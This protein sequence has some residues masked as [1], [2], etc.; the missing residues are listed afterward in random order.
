MIKIYK[1]VMRQYEEGRTTSIS[2]QEM[3][4]VSRKH[5]P[6]YFVSEFDELKQKAYHLAFHIV[7][8]ILEREEIRS[9]IPVLQEPVAENF[10]ELTCLFSLFGVT[11]LKGK[12]HQKYHPNC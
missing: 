11:N 6:E 5:L 3:E 1:W 8:E 9:M 12:N 2:A 7:E 10:I 4:R